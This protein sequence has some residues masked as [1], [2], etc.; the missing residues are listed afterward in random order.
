MPTSGRRV[1]ERSGLAFFAARGAFSLR[2]EVDREDETQIT[3]ASYKLSFPHYL[4]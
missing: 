2:E 1:G 4:S 3:R